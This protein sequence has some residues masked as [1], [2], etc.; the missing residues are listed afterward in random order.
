LIAAVFSYRKADV[1][2]VGSI[3]L[4]ERQIVGGEVKDK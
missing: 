3:S 1:P 2:F 4:L